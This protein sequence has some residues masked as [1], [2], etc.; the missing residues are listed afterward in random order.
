[1]TSAF[2][3]DNGLMKVKPFWINF[4]FWIVKKK[5]KTSYPLWVLIE[6]HTKGFCSQFIDGAVH[7]MVNGKNT[8][9]SESV[10]GFNQEEINKISLFLEGLR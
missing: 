1:M 3:F 2:L 4:A 6:N 9:D 7:H 5:H 8:S 10:G